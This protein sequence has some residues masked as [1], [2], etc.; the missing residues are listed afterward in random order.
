MKNHSVQSFC[1]YVSHVWHFTDPTLSYW[2]EPEWAW[3]SPMLARLHC[4]WCVCKLACLFVCGHLPQTLNE[5]N[6]I[7]EHALRLSRGQQ[8]R[9]TARVQCQHENYIGSTPPHPIPGCDLYFWAQFSRKWAKIYM[10]NVQYACCR[11]LYSAVI[12]DSLMEYPSYWG[13]E[14]QLSMGSVWYWVDSLE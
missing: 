8:Q 5:C 1:G 4:T 13:S 10:N 11:T 7:F 9:A 6:E 14:K 2:S 12:T 3:V